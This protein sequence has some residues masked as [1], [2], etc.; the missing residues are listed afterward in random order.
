MKA[1]QNKFPI[2]V[3]NN[4]DVFKRYFDK[5]IALGQNPLLLL[6][7]LRSRFESQ[8]SH[9]AYVLLDFCNGKY[10]VKAYCC[11]C[12][13]GCRTVGCCGH[14]MVVIW[15]T[16]HIDHNELKLPSSKLDHIFD[17]WNNPVVQPESEDAESENSEVDTDTE[18]EDSTEDKSNTSDSNSSED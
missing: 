7:N 11:S 17:N 6:I 2:Y 1:N 3:C 9:K 13:H 5:K 4:V 18:T 15:Y 10:V 16:L 8:K 12:R 14:V